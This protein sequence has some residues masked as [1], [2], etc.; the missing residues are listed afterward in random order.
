M[1]R[2]PCLTGSHEGTRP[3]PFLPSVVQGCLG[4]PS[5]FSSCVFRG[6]GRKEVVRGKQD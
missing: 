4:P 2:A 6:E 5:S 3:L 1:V